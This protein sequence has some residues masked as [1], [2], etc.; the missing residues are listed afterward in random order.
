MNLNIVQ[1]HSQLWKKIALFLI[2]QN[3]SLFGSS[4]VSF[5]I[6]WYI[7]LQTSSGKWVMLFTI[8]SL[9][10]QVLISLW[11]G[12]WADRYN[13]K[14]LIMLADGFIALATLGL[15]IAFWA[16]YQRMELI[17]AVSLIRSIGAGIQT[18]A[19]SALYPQI[20]PMDKLTKVQGINQ[21]LNSVL[22]L[23]SPAVGGIMLGSLGIFWAFMLD[24]ISAS[25]AIAVLSFIRIE[26]VVRSAE[27]A[28]VFTELRQG[29]DYVLNHKLLKRVLLCFGVSFF[30]ITPAAVLTPL[31]VERS[32]GNDVWRLTA[33][34]IVWT[35]G[36]MIG[37][38]FISLQG[39]FKD[40]IRTVAICLVGFGVT[41]A[42]LGIAANFSI[43]LLIM[44]IAGFFMPIMATAQ[45][46]LIQENVENAMMGR[47]FSLIQIVTGSSMPIAI[48]F[49]G[50]LADIVS[51]GSILL[52]S[53]VL[54]AVVGVWYQ[55]TNKR[56]GL[57]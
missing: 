33:H 29:I 16:G 25:L 41:F 21:T 43:Y 20:V 47:V 4:V 39:D 50:P 45:T 46:V 32:F 44:G 40:K 22:M 12:V 27:I 56:A 6:I 30:L 11:G 23:L 28:P 38:V 15:A 8:C 42:L 51:I 37:G 14:Y 26:K 55:M 10:P 7:T 2:S 53:G 1:D 3:I 5:S 17:L 18:P 35:V 48:L 49:F 9:L 52:V 36:S 24:V 34:E 13:R 57:N 54:L 31:L 19:A